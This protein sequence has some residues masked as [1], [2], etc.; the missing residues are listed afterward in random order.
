M[1]YRIGTDIEQIDRIR[2][3]AKRTPAFFGRCFT[4]R[5]IAYIESKGVG[6]YASAAGLYTAKEAFSK[7]LGT[8]I[9]GFSLCDVEILHDEKGAPYFAF[10]KNLAGLSPDDFTLSISHSGNYA[11]SSV[12]FRTKPVF[13]QKNRYV[14]TAEQMRRA[15]ALTSEKAVSSV[16][17]MDN[18]AK[19]LFDE[20]KKTGGKKAV[21]LCGRGNNGGDGICLSSMLCKSGVDTT[22]VFLGDKPLSKDAEYYFSRLEKGVETLTFTPENEEKIKNII[23]SSDFAVDCIFGTGFKGELSDDFAR[24]LSYINIYTIACDV[25]SGVHA[26]TNTASAGTHKADVTVT[27]GEKKPCHFLFP[28]KDFCGKITV[29]EIGITE[30]TILE[31]GYTARVITPSAVKDFVPERKEN[32]N[33]GSFG[34]LCVACGSEKM[35]G[36]ALL[37]MKGAAASGVGLTVVDTDEKIKNL[38]CLAFPETLF[39]P[40]SKKETAVLVGCGLT[41]N[42]AAV[43][44]QLEKNLPTLLDADALNVLADDISLLEKH[45][46]PK[47]LTPHPLEM[48]RLIGK[49]V[50]YVENNRFS[51]ALDFAEKYSAVLLLKGRHTVIACPDGRL[52]ISDGGNSG[53]AKGGSGDVLA[54]FIAGLLASGFSAEGAALCGVLCQTFAADKLKTEKGERGYTPSDVAEIMG[55]FIP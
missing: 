47:I 51:V 34:T 19:A 21:V 50:E 48:A 49:T 38:I 25:P 4:E 44:K 12:I 1:D 33:K 29:A 2:D 5:E 28:A 42:R 13:G 54:G 22:V 36:A 37:A 18:A 39:S 32:T 8:G 53:L 40:S 26:D 31:A 10:H 52:W 24:L 3:I 14:L 6:K 16:K 17:L 23:A 35:P 45:T 27:F 7:A 20:C 46:A 9:S 11:F 43:E 55:K 41:K 15:D 30:E